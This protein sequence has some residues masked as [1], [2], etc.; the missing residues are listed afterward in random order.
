MTIE[1][2]REAVKAK[3]HKPMLAA[4]VGQLLPQLLNSCGKSELMKIL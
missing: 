1:Q 3:P 4:A 2:Y